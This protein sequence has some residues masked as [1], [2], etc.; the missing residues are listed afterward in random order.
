MDVADDLA[1]FEGMSGEQVR[2]IAGVFGD[3]DALIRHNAG[4]TL[5]DADLLSVERVLCGLCSAA[6]R[7]GLRRAIRDSGLSADKKSA[8]L[9]VGKTR[10]R[11]TGQPRPGSNHELRYLIK[12]M[13]IDETAEIPDTLEGLLG[14]YPDGGED[15]LSL[16]RSLRGRA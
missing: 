15:S 10:G 5:G 13:G 9:Q 7:A 1:A 16:V 12:L 6:G 11:A 4:A 8:L 2:A 14:D 3:L